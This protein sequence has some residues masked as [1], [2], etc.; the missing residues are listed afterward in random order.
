MITEQGVA[1]I[2]L[3]DEKGQAVQL[4]EHAAHPDAREWLWEEAQ[5]LGLV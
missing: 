2:A 1:D 4:I 5:E 3:R